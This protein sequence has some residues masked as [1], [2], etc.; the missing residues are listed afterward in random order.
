[1]NFNRI[2]AIVIRQLY[3]W[4]RSLER[5]QGSLGWPLL[6]LISWGMTM[7]FFQK[8]VS[9]GFSIVA[10]LLGGVIF[11]E[12]TSISQRE[13]S[14]NFLDEAWNRNLINIFSSPITS[15][16]FLIAS[17]ILGLIKLTVTMA[18]MLLGALIFYQFN[19]FTSYSFYIPFFISN[20]LIFGISLGLVIN[21]LILRYGYNIAEL[22]WALVGWVSPFSCIY[23]PLSAIPVWAQK[24]AMILPSTYVFEE[25][26]RMVLHHYVIWNNILISLLLN[27]IYL[28]LS[29]WFF[30][31]M[32]AKAKEQ[33]RLVKLN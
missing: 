12:L 2:I 33:G 27:G 5:W 26:R 6:G 28:I 13:I 19:I 25:M 1:M 20:L 29:I 16:E 15:G 3:I 23:Y 31:I 14:V 10:F 8:N 17:V 7:S 22:T 4:P 24:I 21:G 11:W 30:K 32:F 9:F 18:V